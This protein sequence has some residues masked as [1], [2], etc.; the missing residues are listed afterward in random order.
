MPMGEDVHE[1]L[2]IIP[3][4]YFVVRHTRLRYG[5]GCGVGRIVTCMSKQF[6]RHDVGV[7]IN[8]TARN[9]VRNTTVTATVYWV[10]D[11]ALMREM[12]QFAAQRIVATC[13]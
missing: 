10:G 13:P 2:S 5:C 7:T 9:L 12:A 11:Q 3:R 4:Q 6:D 8:N 1:Q